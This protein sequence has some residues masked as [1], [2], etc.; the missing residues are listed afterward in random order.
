MS[1]KIVSF[2]NII[3]M[4]NFTIRKGLVIIKL[5]ICRKETRTRWEEGICF[6]CW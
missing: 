4:I 3:T 5:N 1:F 2:I 6:I